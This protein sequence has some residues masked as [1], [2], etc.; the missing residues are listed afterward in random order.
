MATT[1]GTPSW[2]SVVATP[3]YGSVSVVRA[4]SQELSTTRRSDV[5]SASRLASSVP[6][7]SAWSAVVV[8][9]VQHALAGGGEVAVADEVQD[10][11]AAVAQAPRAARRGVAG[12]SQ[13]SW[14]RPRAT[15]LATACSTR[16]ALAVDVERGCSRSGWRRR[17]GS[18]RRQSIAGGC[19]SD[20]VVEVAHERR[21]A[22]VGEEARPAVQQLPRHAEQRRRGGQR[23][24]Q[25]Q[26]PPGRRR[27]VPRAR[28]SRRRCP[29][30]AAPSASAPPE[31]FGVELG[32]RR[33]ADVARSRPVTGPLPCGD[34]E[35]GALQLVVG[36]RHHEASR[37]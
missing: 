33:A 7:T 30:S 1:A 6:S 27:A 9:E 31:L 14:T 37:V 13:S 23:Q 22:L 12:S 15:I 36:E 16:R 21:L 2:T 28:R 8:L 4:P 32:R 29:A 19:G 34:A 24:R 11:V 3:A 10:V 20:G 17:R 25:P 35:H 26:P 18:A 5:W